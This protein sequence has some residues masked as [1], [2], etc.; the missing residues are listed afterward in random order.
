M[1]QRFAKG[2]GGTLRLRPP[3]ARS[4]GIAPTSGTVTLKTALGLDVPVPVVDQAVTVN[5]DALEFVL[6]AANTPDPVT[7]G[8]LEP[9][10]DPTSTP[11][12]QSGYLYRAV[13]TYVVDGATYQTDLTYEVNARI[14][15]PTLI[16]ADVEKWLPSKWDELLDVNQNPPDEIVG[17]AWDDLLDDLLDRDFQPDRIMTPERLSR[18]HRER[19]IANLYKTLGPRWVESYKDAWNAYVRE[20]NALLAAPGWYDRNMDTRGSDAETK[21]AT[22]VLGR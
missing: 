10:L 21:V 12:I 17:G 1:R 15:K 5:G 20:L 4:L 13:W 18:V 11:A 6:V 19:V 22:I 7:A 9:A 8:Y 3:E 16:A 2:M 14:L